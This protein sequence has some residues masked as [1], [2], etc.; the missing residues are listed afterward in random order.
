MKTLVN[1]DSN[2]SLFIFEDAEIV[3]IQ[4]DK[5]LVG[6][7]PSMVISD[8]N[9][10]NVSLIESVTPPDDYLEWKYLYTVDNGWVLN[11]AWVD[12]DTEPTV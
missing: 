1:L 10:T 7:P 5:T 6:N 2:I 4:A 8:C 3:D 11:P 12:F 9:S